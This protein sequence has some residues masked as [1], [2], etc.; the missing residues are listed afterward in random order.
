MGKTLLTWKCSKQRCGSGNPGVGGSHHDVI[1]LG[2]GISTGM[3]MCK[4][5]YSQSP[6][7]DNLYNVV[8]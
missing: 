7:F 3:Q 6:V 2:L 5:F 1:A 8:R 4:R